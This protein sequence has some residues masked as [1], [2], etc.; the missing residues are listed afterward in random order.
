MSLWQRLTD[1]ANMRQRLAEAERLIVDLSATNSQLHEENEHL[2]QRNINLELAYQRMLKVSQGLYDTVKVT[3]PGEK[4][5][6]AIVRWQTD[7]GI[8]L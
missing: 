5:V 6:A 3:K 4:R 1:L 7:E 2:K 8:P